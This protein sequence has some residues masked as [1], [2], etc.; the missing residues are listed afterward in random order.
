MTD[1]HELLDETLQQIAELRAEVQILRAR[2]SDLE[3]R[4]AT[5]NPRRSQSVWR[6]IPETP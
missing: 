3:Y 6:H 4:L 2:V 5:E 1:Y